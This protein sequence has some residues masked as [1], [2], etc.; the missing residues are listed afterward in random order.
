MSGIC[1]GN[2]YNYH[3]WS[4]HCRC[5]RLSLCL[6]CLLA[7][8]SGKPD[9]VQE[10]FKKDANGGRLSIFKLK[11]AIDNV[12]LSSVNVCVTVGPKA[13]RTPPSSPGRLPLVDSAF[14][15]RVALGGLQHKIIAHGPHG[16]E[17]QLREFFRIRFLGVFP[18]FR[19]HDGAQ[20]GGLGGL[21]EERRK[22]G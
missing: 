7:Q 22:G 1:R 19:G 20:L 6:P 18:E 17:F 2:L 15:S 14:E 4:T 3:A 9:Q 10:F 16:R 12:Y 8:A 21:Y 13:I 5:R 11:I